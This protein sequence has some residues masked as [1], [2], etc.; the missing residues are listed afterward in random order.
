MRLSRG[1]G[2]QLRAYTTSTTLQTHTLNTQ[3]AL[4]RPLKSGT[5]TPPSIVERDFTIYPNYYALGECRELL[6]AALWK[7]DR[8][9]TL[10]RRKRNKATEEGIGGS[11]DVEGLQRLFGGNYGFEEVCCF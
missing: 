5:R 11:D 8:S 6:Q 10:L 2:R 3:S 4:I 9:D 7:L 1:I